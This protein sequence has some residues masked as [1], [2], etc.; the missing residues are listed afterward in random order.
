MK[1][2]GARQFLLRNPCPNG[3]FHLRLFRHAN[4]TSI[5][6]L[7]PHAYRRR[8][9]ARRAAPVRSLPPEMALVQKA[10]L[11]RRVYGARSSSATPM[12]TRRPIPISTPSPMAVSEGA[13]VRQWDRCRLMSA[14][15]AR[16]PAI[17]CTYELHVKAAPGRSDARGA[18]PQPRARRRGLM[19]LPERA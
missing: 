6:G 9:G 12:A 4:G 8:L 18:C 3:R 1:A 11:V 19:V 2:A 16:Q 13:R 5:L 14:R 7:Q 15:P 10:G 17:T